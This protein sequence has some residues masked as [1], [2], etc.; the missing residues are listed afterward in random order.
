MFGK[1]NDQDD[2]LTSLITGGK[3]R[4][5]PASDTAKSQEQKVQDYNNQ[6]L[7]NKAPAAQTNDFASAVQSYGTTI[8]QVMAGMGERRHKLSMHKTRQP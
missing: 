2:D 8:E 4:S 1:K 7:K 6:V 3:V 5:K